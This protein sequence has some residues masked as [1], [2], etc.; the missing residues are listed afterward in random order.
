M[1]IPMVGFLS[2]GSSI[3]WVTIGLLE[4]HLNMYLLPLSLVFLPAFAAAGRC[5]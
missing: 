1:S 4:S 5:S 3:S 2:G